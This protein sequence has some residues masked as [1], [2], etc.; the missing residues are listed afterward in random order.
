M[1]QKLKTRTVGEIDDEEFDRA[2]RKSLKDDKEL[3]AKLA[4]V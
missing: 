4:K 1:P 2:V 3:L